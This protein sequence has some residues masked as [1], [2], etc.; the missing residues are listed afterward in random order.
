MCFQ[1]LAAVLAALLSLAVAS[2]LPVVVRSRPSDG[3]L[4]LF[5]TKF[6][7]TVGSPT[8]CP[9]TITHN[10]VYGSN[11]DEGEG[12]VMFSNIKMDREDCSPDGQMLLLAR[13]LFSTYSAGGKLL[14][15]S[16]EGLEAVF[17]AGLDSKARVCGENVYSDFSSYVFS[18]NMPQIFPSLL[19]NGFIV[20]SDLVDIDFANGDKG[21]IAVNDVESSICIYRGDTAAA[22][23]LASNDKKSLAI[24]TT[25]LEEPRPSPESSSEP[26][27]DSKADSTE[28]DAPVTDFQSSIDELPVFDDAAKASRKRQTDN[29]NKNCFPSSATVQL[30]DGNVKTMDRLQLGDRILVATGAYSDVLM[31][32][33]RLNG[34]VNDFIRLSTSTGAQ[35]SLTSGHFI[36][37]NGALVAADTIK[38]GDELELAPGGRSTVASVTRVAERGL[39][40]PQT[41]SGDIAVNGIRASTYTTAVR[42]MVAH[43]L[44]APA[45]LAYSLLGATT[46]ILERGCDRFP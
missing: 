9:S 34:T 23:E 7:L 13:A 1:A 3:A 33:H 43:S 8:N 12:R 38:A 45:R 25:E 11:D 21:M 6:E 32:T 22:A 2:R 10:A 4:R 16:D 37:A 5:K 31:F 28:E 19:E 42:P 15:L 29:A 17:I 41:L 27:D 20:E 14:N 26:L 44:L 24:P 36:Y 46:S 39:Y 18:Q 40:N 30:E 35:L